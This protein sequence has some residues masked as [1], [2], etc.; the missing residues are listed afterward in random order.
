MI[1]KLWNKVGCLTTDERIEKMWH[2]YTM[3]YCSAIKKNKIMSFAGKWMELEIIMLS[4]INQ[5][6]KTSIT[7]FLSYVE[8]KKYKKK[9]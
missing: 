8:S 1:A 9:I 6:Q 4:E 7:H 5:T 3:E 2:I